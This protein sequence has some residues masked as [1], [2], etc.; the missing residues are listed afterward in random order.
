M[1]ENLNFINPHDVSFYISQGNLLCLEFKGENIGRVSV[2][3]MFPF[4]YADEYIAVCR[5]NYARIDYEN[6]IGI[7]RNIN[8]L[9]DEQFSI[10][11]N[12]LE[13]RN[14]IPEILKVEHIKE[15][16]GNISFKVD[17]TAGKSEFVITDMGS[18]I[19]N[20]GLDKIMLTDVYGNRYCIPNINSIDDK[21]MKILEIW[22]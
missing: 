4:Q 8:D 3:R 12:E 22:I 6:E 20:I 17:T 18:N 15:E 11:R 13:K 1:S 10:L 2:K 21:T 19:K 7:I 14:F 5:E 9:P 16:Y